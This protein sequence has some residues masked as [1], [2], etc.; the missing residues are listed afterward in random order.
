MP[1]ETPEGPIEVGVPHPQ[2]SGK[3][4]AKKGTHPWNFMN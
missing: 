2:T 1:G 3:S 4:S